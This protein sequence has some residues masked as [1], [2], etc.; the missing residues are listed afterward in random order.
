MVGFAD[1]TA[2]NKQI[3]NIIRGEALRNTNLPSSLFPVFNFSFFHL[4]IV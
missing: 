2:T 3:K 4:L 1:E